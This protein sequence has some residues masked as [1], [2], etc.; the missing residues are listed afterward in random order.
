MGGEHET[1]T[2]PDLTRGIPLADIAEGAMV[3]GHAHGKPVLLVRRGEEVFAIGALCTHYSAP[4]ADGIVVG[5]TVRCPWH[6]ACFSLRTGEALSAPA[7]NPVAHWEIERQ[8]G[9]VSVRREMPAPDGA[10]PVVRVERTVSPEGSAD[11]LPASVVIVGAGGAGNAAAEMLRREGYAG[12]VT[13]IGADNSVPYDRPNLSKDYLAG[14]A[15]EAWIP[16]R[17]PEFYAEHTIELLLG[18][19]VTAVD[20]RA[21]RVSLD[22]G[23]ALGFGALL[24][25]TGAEPVRLP[26]ALHGGHPVHYLRTLADSRA[27]IAAAE[28]ARRAVV[29]GASFIA[30]E[31]AAALRARGLAVHVVGPEPRPLEKV[32]GPELGDFIRRL[33]EQHGVAFH[34]GQRAS[35]IDASGVT[36]GSGERVAADL[37]V[38][39]IGVRPNIELA[40]QAG[41][42][43]DRGVVVDEYLETSVPGVYAA[44]DIAR[45]PDPR[46]GERVR[47]EHWVVAE[48]QGQV[49]ARNMLRGRGGAVRERYDAV[50]FFWSNHYDTP[51]HYVGHAERWDEVRVTGRVADGDCAVAFRSAGETLAVAT[52]GRARASLAAE[53]AMER[54]DRRAL[55]ALLAA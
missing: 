19:R 46:T 22:D 53:A 24:L 43:L 45:Y 34:L 28:G 55:D 13:M 1:L 48:R 16:L 11:T 32:L 5:D 25:A 2:G 14:N 50:P 44:G 9:T 17:S 36:L 38:A 20:T 33:H 39:G 26:A 35:Q 3:A 4:L 40:A 27:I 51:V 29:L 7:L 54:G 15:P 49:A 52:V 10:T 42:A 31:V 23:R 37:V 18:R 47:V 8:D 6:H 30:L 21:Q 41:L 12:P